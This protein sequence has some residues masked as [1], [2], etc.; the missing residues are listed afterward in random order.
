MHLEFEKPIAEL[1][2]KLEDMKQLASGKNTDV[3]DAVKSLE[4]RI[5]ELKKET[6][7]TKMP[8]M[9][10]PVLKIKY[11]VYDSCLVNSDNIHK[12]PKY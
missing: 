1:E 10:P 12:T 11:P 7:L 5:K 4:K 6:F 3:K 2:D 8:G 9:Y